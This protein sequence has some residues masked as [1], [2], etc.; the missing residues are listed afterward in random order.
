MASFGQH[1]NI[2]AIT[3][4]VL[5]VSIHSSGLLTINQSIL[6]LSLGVIG[7]MLPDLDSE[8]SKPIQGTFTMLSILLPLIFLL[9]ISEELS[10]LTMVV[11]WIVASFLLHIT[12]FKLFLHVTIHRGIFHS[13]P[14]ALLFGELCTIF[15]YKIVQ[16]PIEFSI[17]YGF[18]ITFGFIT[19]L[20]L[21]EIFSINALGM[22]MKKSFGT[23]LKLYAK[24]NITGTLILYA[25]VIL[26]FISFP[27]EH[28]VYSNILQTIRDIKIV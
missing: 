10:L 21:D 17:I 15:F 14:M 25:L 28:S 22:R 26:L 5:V 4:G 2:S 16:T 27:F 13:I 12:I 8:N 11:T 9:S 7:G 20:I 19:H 18:F 3:T 24:N 23:A 6:A 1:I